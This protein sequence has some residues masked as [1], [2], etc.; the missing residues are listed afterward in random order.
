M[1]YYY[2]YVKFVVLD[3]MIS[4]FVMSSLKERYECND[5]ISS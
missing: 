1:F 3:G 4:F 5:L 2:Y